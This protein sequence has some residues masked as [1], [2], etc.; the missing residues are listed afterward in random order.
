MQDEGS[1]NTIK[2]NLLCEVTTEL[3]IGSEFANTFEN[4]FINEQIPQN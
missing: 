1:P 2:D 4:Q 3:P